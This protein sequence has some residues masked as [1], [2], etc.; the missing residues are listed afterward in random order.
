MSH[1][2]GDISQKRLTQNVLEGSLDGIAEARHR[3]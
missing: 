2:K 1:G 3:L